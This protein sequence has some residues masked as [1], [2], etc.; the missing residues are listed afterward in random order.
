MEHRRV[1]RDS[2]RLRTQ[3]LTLL[4]RA[5]AVAAG[6]ARAGHAPDAAALAAWVAEGR[7]AS[8]TWME[9]HVNLRAHTDS[10][11][12]GAVSI[13]CAAFPY[14]A[15]G[16]P[17]I[18]PYAVGEDYHRLLR[19]RLR[20]VA[21][22][23]HDEAGGKW[24]VCVD[25]A[26]LSERAWAVQ[27]GLGFTGRNGCLIVPR[28]GSRVF[29]GEI[30]TDVEI[31]PDTPYAGS[32]LGCGRC[33]RECPTRALAPDGYVD[34]RR[35]LGYLTVEHRGTFTPEQTEYVRRGGM[36]VG[37]DVCQAV[38]PHNRLAAP[39]EPLPG[40]TPAQD[41]TDLTPAIASGMSDEEFRRRF[42][43]GPLGRLGAEGLR[44]N[45]RAI[46]SADSS[47]DRESR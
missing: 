46:T 42:G 6:V 21:A 47:E 20:E 8:M 31:E 44:R 24:R 4:H 27:A 1:G 9:R 23:L 26:P 15:T 13:L 12:P 22:E 36:L 35:C 32:C 11:M 14:N 3:A 28:V 19:E 34:S 43:S 5:G 45:A 29:L 39:V 41:A 16:A 17:Y 37:C 10:V 33:V 38:C 2:S 18:A 40:L 30:L 7:H 25:S